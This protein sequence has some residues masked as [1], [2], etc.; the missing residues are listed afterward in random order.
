[1]MIS[2]EYQGVADY[3]Y[4]RSQSINL[5]PLMR[6]FFYAAQPQVFFQARQRRIFDH[7]GKLVDGFPVCS[8][9]GDG[10][11]DRPGCAGP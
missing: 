5:A 9:D 4:I 8:G 10:K 3:G 7:R 6:R 11:W 1:M 2:N